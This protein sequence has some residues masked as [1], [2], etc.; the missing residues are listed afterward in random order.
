MPVE[1][2]LFP[3]TESMAPRS[4]RSSSADT[5][6][7][8]ATAA[9]VRSATDADSLSVEE[10]IYAS[11]TTALLQGRLR[12]GAQLVERDLAAAF[13][14]TRGALRKVLARL[15]FEGKLVLEANRGAF[16]PSPSEEDIRQVY[17]ARQ[18]VEAG[19]VAALCGAL[20]AAHKR[21]LRAH[22]RSEEKALRAGAID[23][24]VRLAG[25]FHVL[26]TELAGGTELL[27]L[28]RRRA[29][30][31]HRRARCGRP[32]SSIDGDARAS[33]GTGRAGGRTDAQK[34]R[35][36]GS[37]SGVRAVGRSGAVGR[38]WRAVLKRRTSP[39]AGKR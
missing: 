39:R 27:G 10:R 19:I 26:L 24:S 21:R 12:P 1:I 32:A 22:V 13:G 3:V 29:R 6:T 18:I 25:Q 2:A 15:G 36:R 37:Q 17:R 31:H 34:R 14:C 23:E 30:A 11:I 28:F 16:V 33:V 38:K 8:A 35:R 9:P 5:R 20:S 4:R 7:A